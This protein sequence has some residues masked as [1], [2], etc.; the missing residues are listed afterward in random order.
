LRVERARKGVR[1]LGAV[2][3]EVLATLGLGDPAEARL[4][5]EWKEAAG[6]E[7]AASCQPAALRAGRLT[8][9]PAGEAWRYELTMRSEELKLRLNSYL[10]GDHVKEV[11]VMAR[12]AR[13]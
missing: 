12:R 8:V 2:V 9:V 4:H 6:G 13:V 5:A 10:G 3:T 11:A 1:A 7:F